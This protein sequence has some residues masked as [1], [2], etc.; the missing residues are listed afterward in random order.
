MNDGEDKVE[1]AR[2]RAEFVEI[3]KAPMAPEEIVRIQGEL[4]VINAKIKAINTTAAAQQ[5]AAADRRRAAGL[6]EARANDTRARAKINSVTR[7]PTIE[8]SEDDDPGQTAAIDGW[9]DAVLLRYDVDFTRSNTGELV[10]GGDPKWALLMS[11]LVDGIYA[12]ARGQ[13]LP[14]LP[15]APRSPSMQ[16]AIADG[17]PIVTSPPVECLPPKPTPKAAKPSRPATTRKRP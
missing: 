3:L 2:R 5:K 16:G 15:S 4:R 8:D 13:E 1:L 9:I 7:G 6:A 14:D 17:R 10:L 11:T 12:A